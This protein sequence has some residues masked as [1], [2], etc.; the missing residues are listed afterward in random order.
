MISITVDVLHFH[1]PLLLPLTS[2]RW[3]YLQTFFLLAITIDDVSMTIA[4]TG[5][6]HRHH[7]LTTTVIILDD[8]Y[9]H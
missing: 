7:C 5:I 4:T 1:Q 9:R 2:N 6:G 8:L 3:H